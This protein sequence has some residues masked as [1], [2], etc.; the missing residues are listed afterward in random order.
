MATQGFKYEITNAAVDAVIKIQGQSGTARSF[1]Q[2]DLAM[3]GTVASIEAGE[4]WN[5]YLEA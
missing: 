1:Y 5:D 3:M 2:N 4:P